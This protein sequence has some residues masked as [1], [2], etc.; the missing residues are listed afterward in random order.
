M[1][2]PPPTSPP[3]PSAMMA[4]M[5]LLL[6]SAVWLW[7]NQRQPPWV[8][9]P[10]AGRSQTPSTTQSSQ[11]GWRPWPWPPAAWP[12]RTASGPVPQG[13]PAPTGPQTERCPFRRGAVS[14]GSPPSRPNECPSQM[15]MWAGWSSRND[16]PS[17]SCTYWWFYLFVCLLQDF[18]QLNQYR[19]NKEIGK[20]SVYTYS[21][22]RRGAEFLKQSFLPCRGH[23]EWWNWLIMK[24]RN[25]TMQV[26]P[27]NKQK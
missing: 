14:P 9:T 10:P 23:M 3:P 24:I 21:C 5:L 22:S 27:Q 20:A 25:S 11:T 4:A 17:W 8:R 26:L 13:Q 18:V 15:P 16:T 6:H 12:L 7:G 2:L 1:L 19:M